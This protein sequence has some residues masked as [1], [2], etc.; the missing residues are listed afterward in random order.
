M[1]KLTNRLAALCLA[2]MAA[3]GAFAAGDD[4]K[5]EL[6]H[7]TRNLLKSPIVEVNPVWK[8]KSKLKKTLQ[9]RTN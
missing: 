4:F 8:I 2:A 6:M 5:Y 1:K 3:G 7:Y 9:Q